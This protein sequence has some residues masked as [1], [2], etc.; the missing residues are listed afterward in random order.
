MNKTQ[1]IDAIAANLDE[2]K[3]VVN[4]VVDA[5][6]DSI[7]QALAKSEQVEIVGFGKWEVKQRKARTGRNPKTGE[8][9]EIAATN[10]AHFKAGK[11]MKDAVN[12][13]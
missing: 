11:G 7:K 1:L 12:G 9:I 2:P 5:I 10:V 4:R 13:G 8:S 3:N 6:F